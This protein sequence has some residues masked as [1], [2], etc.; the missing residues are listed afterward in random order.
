MSRL[1]KE[2]WEPRASA[3]AALWSLREISWLPEL[4]T[5]RVGFCTGQHG[6]AVLKV[7]IEPDM[8]GFEAA[9]LIHFGPEICPRV[10]GLSTELESI[11][12]ERFEVAEDMSRHYPRAEDEV[13]IW[14]P[15]F[16]AVRS[17]MDVPKG[18][19]TLAQ[20][21]EVFK[22][23]LKMTSD[24]EIRRLLRYADERKGILMGD[25]NENR[26][27]HGDMH[28]FNILRDVKQGWRLIDP[29]GVV[30]HPLYELGAFLRNPW[31]PCYTEPGVR[32]R[33]A[34][35][36][37]ILA[38]RLTVPRTVVAEYGFYGAAISIAWSIEEGSTDI[39]GMVVMAEACLGE[40]A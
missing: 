35:R 17:R 19:A 30:G 34:E 31:G 1:L 23:T 13:S 33:L 37:D 40:V 20:Y 22:R 39:E 5:A 4:S 6:P 32:S 3:A 18:F 21:S 36:I 15:I 12:L 38:E 27:L 11:L 14:L 28:H 16:D 10:Q 24:S 26:L 8:V 29:H 9:A 25:A 7:S 2:N